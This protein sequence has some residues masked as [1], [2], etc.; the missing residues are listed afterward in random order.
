MVWFYQ[1]VASFIPDVL[2]VVVA[3]HCHHFDCFWHKSHCELAFCQ[4]VEGFLDLFGVLEFFHHYFVAIYGGKAVAIF[5]VKPA[6]VEVF[7]RLDILNKQNFIGGFFAVNRIGEKVF[8]AGET[9]FSGIG[10]LL[11]AGGIKD[12]FIVA[13]PL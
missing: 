2:G 8:E 11:V 10:V 1:F 3:Q 7:S 4:A 9:E 5:L 6:D 13:Q 12:S